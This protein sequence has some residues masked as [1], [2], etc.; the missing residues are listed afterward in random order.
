MCPPAHQGLWAAAGEQGG[1]PGHGAALQHTGGAAAAGGCECAC[2]QCSCACL[3][4]RWLDSHVVLVTPGEDMSRANSRQGMPP[5]LSTALPW[6]TGPQVVSLHCS[7]SPATQLL[8]G[9]ER[10]ALMK[11]DALLVNTARGPVVD[12]AALVAHLQ[13]HPHFRAGGSCVPSSLAS[14]LPFCA[15]LRCNQLALPAL[16]RC[17]IAQGQGLCAAAS[18]GACRP[19]HSRRP[20]SF[21][22]RLPPLVCPFAALD[23]FEREPLMEP[24][25][26]ECE[27]AVVVPHIASATEWTRSGMVSGWVSGWPC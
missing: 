2:L 4:V 12:E 27:N 16:A 25:L 8:I 9:A 23:V 26:A 6:R 17:L 1:A 24:G 22:S 13:S 10:L 18:C 21:L 15:A 11:P 14:S 7:L 3:L 20:L 5:E 19:L